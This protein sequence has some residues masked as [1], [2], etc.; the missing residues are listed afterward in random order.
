MCWMC[1]AEDDFHPD[2]WT[3]EMLARPAASWT[4]SDETR[5]W[6]AA[7]IAQSNPNSD[8]ASVDFSVFAGSAIDPPIDDPTLSSLTSIELA[9]RIACLNTALATPIVF[10][11]SNAAARLLSVQFETSMPSDQ[12]AAYAGYT[13]QI[14]FTE[15]EKL[16]FRSVFADYEMYLNIDLQ[17]VSG[18]PDADISLQHTNLESIYGGRGRFVT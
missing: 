1:A 5:A 13:G 8:A 9:D 18:L 11:T 12:P 3:P 14:G 4:V 6:A 16:Q 15:A 17:E 10:N 2:Q 7:A